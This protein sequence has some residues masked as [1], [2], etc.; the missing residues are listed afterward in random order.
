MADQR[1]DEQP[2]GPPSGAP[3]G[4]SSGWGQGGGSS[5]GF[6]IKTVV[7][8][9]GPAP[10]IA[11]AELPIRV[12][13]YIIDA[14]ILFFCYIIVASILVAVLVISG[15]WFITWVLTAVLY[16][17]GSAIYFVWSWTHLRASPGQK[18]LNLETVSATNGG[19]IDSPVAIRRYLYLFGPMLL[20]QVFSI[21]GGFAFPILGYLV[22]LF[23]LGYAI[24]LLYT[25]SQ[26]PKRQ[27]FH[28]VQ[29]GTV[30]VQRTSTIG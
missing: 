16:A 12:G 15:A 5:S 2:P 11:Y 6:Q 4:G 21:G 20:A 29:A 13:A 23:S 30:V 26:S 9:A 1:P 24:W 28:D 3:S 25:V 18:I 8:E 22:S 27:G 14:L 7:P 10:G 17:A 19:T